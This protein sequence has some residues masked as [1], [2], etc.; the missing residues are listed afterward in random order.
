MPKSKGEG[1]VE[2]EN[3]KGLL[4]KVRRQYLVDSLLYGVLFAISF[5]IATGELSRQFDIPILRN[6]VLGSVIIVGAYI[7]I[8][9]GQVARYRRKFRLSLDVIE[10]ADEIL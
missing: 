4:K 10:I 8:W 2:L 5:G 9:V 7:L 6:R 3:L 1:V